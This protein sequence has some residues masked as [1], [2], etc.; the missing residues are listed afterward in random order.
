MKSSK[1]TITT[2]NKVTTAV[3][4]THNIQDVNTHMTWHLKHISVARS[5]I[6]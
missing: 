4:T 6:L 3:K 2:V 5:L 1:T